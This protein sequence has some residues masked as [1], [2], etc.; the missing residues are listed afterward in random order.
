MLSRRHVIGATVAGAWCISSARAQPKSS[1]P[2]RTLHARARAAA[3]GTS[4]KAL[5][6][7]YD[8]TVPGPVLRVKQGEELHV[9]LINDLPEPTSVHWSGVRLSNIMD[10]VA[11]LTQP[12]VEP[13]RSFD[14]RF[15]PPDAGTFYYR[16]NSAGQ[17]DSGLYGAL[18]VEEQEPV[19]ADRDVVLMLGTADAAEPRA[20]LLVNGAVQ[21]DI[22][23][24]VGERL[25]IR[26]INATGVRGLSFK[27]QAHTPWVMAIDG[28]PV[29]PFL[30]NDGRAGLAPGNRVD[31]FFDAAGA[32]GVVAPVLAGIRDEAP[33]ARLVYQA[34]S[35]P[36]RR[37]GLQPRPLPSNP[38]PARI[39]LRNALRVAMTIGASG[40]RSTAPIF[41][42]S[43]GRGVNLAL[44]NPSGHPHVV[45]VH[46]HHFRLLDRLDDGWKPYWLD[47]LVVGE[48]GERIAFV[49]DNP[50][51]WLIESR[52]LD[53]DG[54]V[55]AVWFAVT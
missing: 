13:G 36:P 51:K 32:A 15:R 4:G 8:D 34:G 53:R 45:H 37:V 31:L 23:I 11:G 3:A 16:A 12:S 55:A 22:P 27:V 54:P 2:P 44:Q 28:Q 18:L 43:R 47:T 10:G 48:L 41:S 33:I 6:F 24:A 50:G 21:P 7:G 42:V 49:A 46:G 14:Y 29:E 30:P 35:R 40:G 38:L 17:A 52:P 19:D 39:D 20:P 25:R 5:R 1:T 9:Q 26:V